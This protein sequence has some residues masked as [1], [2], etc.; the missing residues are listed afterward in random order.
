L[1]VTAAVLAVAFEIAIEIDDQASPETLTRLDE[2]SRRLGHATATA[3]RGRTQAEL[4][5]A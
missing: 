2:L 5:H 4:H 3:R 1:V